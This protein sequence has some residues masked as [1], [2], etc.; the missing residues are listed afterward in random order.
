MSSPAAGP[1]VDTGA[2][3]ADLAAGRLDVAEAEALLSQD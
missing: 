2:I 1:D 3:L